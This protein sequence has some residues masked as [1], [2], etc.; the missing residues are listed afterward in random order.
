ML[1][2]G[3]PIKNTD[4]KTSEYM[5]DWMTNL[6]KTDRKYKDIYNTAKQIGQA[7]VNPQSYS[8]GPI[9]KPEGELASGGPAKKNLPYLVGEQGPEIFVPGSNGTVIPNGAGTSTEEVSVS[10]SF[11]GKNAGSMRGSKQTA[12]EL[13]RQFEI[14]QGAIS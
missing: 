14:M 3:F 2:E 11:N 13:L 6:D 12:A 4:D 7:T 5:A 9:F 8:S 10:F 1:N